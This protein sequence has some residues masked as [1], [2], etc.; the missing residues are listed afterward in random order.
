MNN[1]LRLLL[2]L[3][4]GAIIT[5]SIFIIPLTL[6]SYGPQ[7][8]TKPLSSPR[9]YITNDSLCEGGD[10]YSIRQKCPE[11]IKIATGEP[12]VAGASARHR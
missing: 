10:L 7:F 2:M 12:E 9:K 1:D 8:E 4:S 5:G 11:Y 3:I 6:F